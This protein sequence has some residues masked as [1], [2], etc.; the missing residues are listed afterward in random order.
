MPTPKSLVL[1]IFSASLLL[2]AC[3]ENTETTQKNSPGNTQVTFD[4]TAGQK[5]PWNG[6]LYSATSTDGLTFTEKKLVLARAGVPNL[7]KLENGDLILTYEY[8]S[9]T[10]AKLFS[11][12]TYSTSSDQGSTWSAPTAIQLENL[13]TPID[14]GKTP[15]D[16]TL[17]QTQEGALRLYFTYAAKGNKTAA[18]YSA[19]A[20]DGN[21]T[22]P[23]VVQTTPALMLDAN[24][25]DPSIIFFNGVWHHY[26]EHDGSNSVNYH[27]TST[28]GLTFTRQEDIT[29]DMAL[30][31]QVIPFDNGL[32]FYG[33][34]KG[35]TTAFSTDGYTWT[36]DG[37][38]LAQGGDPAVQKLDDGSY[39]M[40]YTSM[41]QN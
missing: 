20:A 27:S 25:L 29:L 24:V 31:G 4:Q 7:L 40:V 9:D 3:T 15:M 34:G 10:D 39:L 18:L 5:G 21:I 28:D 41:S 12:I 23:F 6:S 33:S 8:F 36:I 30:L 32:R 11:V 26:A 38:N 35:V 14:P 13:P 16:P 37:T 2:S 19:T 22:S 17:V 1:L